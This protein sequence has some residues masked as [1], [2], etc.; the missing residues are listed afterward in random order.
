MKT[1]LSVTWKDIQNGL[2]AGETAI[3]FLRFAYRF[4]T[5]LTGEPD[6][7]YYAALLVRAQD[8]A[9]VF[10]PLFEE[11]ELLVALKKYA[12]KG[13]M[14][15]R[16]REGFKTLQ[17]SGSPIYNLL[18][19]PLEQYLQPG[20]T[21][22]FSPDGLL[23]RLAFAAIPYGKD[24]YLCDNY[25]LVQLTSTQ[26]ILQEDHK[27][28][29]KTLIALFGGIH[30]SINSDNQTERP[31]T[32]R[33]GVDSFYYLPHTLKEVNNIREQ[34]GKNK[35]QYQLYTADEATEQTFKKLNGAGSPEI[36][37]FATH[38]FTYSTTTAAKGLAGEIFKNAD[39]PL[40][41]CGL[42]MAGGNSGWMGR[43]EPD[44]EDGI[45]TGLEIST[46]QLP[47]TRLA[48][49]S[50][51]E[52][53]LGEIEGSE[54]VL[55]L[56]RAFKLAGVDYIMASL[57][58]VPDKETAQFMEIFYTNL[59]DGKSSIREAFFVTQQYMRKRYAP[60]YWAGFTL[61]Q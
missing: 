49:L 25:K 17:L 16:G 21:V 53:G 7:V 47:N 37:H 42:V 29:T 31:A 61:V 48:V 5:Y 1:A 15:T 26:Q 44:K 51:C 27:D 22:Y 9:P 18:W 3:E 60:Y 30:Y 12:Y 20:E 55:G 28:Y 33:S 57:W 4:N 24:K 10:I 23:H 35:W 36:I 43:N 50:A 38:G 14:A 56:Q 58:Q 41:R 6:T 13:N 52:T 2:K 59:L 34:S 32:L 46:V 19:K 8:T 45:L 40:V 54:G 39:N 11:K